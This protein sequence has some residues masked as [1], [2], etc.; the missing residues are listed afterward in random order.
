MNKNSNQL[1]KAG[2]AVRHILFPLVLLLWP[3]VSIRQGVTV[4]D[5][6]YSLA[7][8]RYL[9][10]SGTTWFYAT[11]LANK[12][13][14]LLMKLPL[15]RTMAGMNLL[16]SLLIS[17]TALM[18]YYVLKRRFSAGAVFLGE[19]IAIALCWCPAAILYNYLTYFLLTVG[20]LC[21]LGFAESAEK[22][23]GKRETLFLILAGICLGMNVGVRLSNLAEAALILAVWFYTWIEGNSGQ[24]LKKIL[25]RTG[26]CILG[27]LLGFAVPVLWSAVLYGPTAYFK[28]IPA[29]FS[30][31]G[32]V[33]SYT[34]GGMLASVASAYLAAGKWSLIMLAAAAASVLLF[35]V[36]LPGALRRSRIPVY[37]LCLAVLTRLLY[38]RGM[39]TVNYQDYWC[40]FSWG[41]QFLLLALLLGAAGLAGPLD[42]SRTERFYAALAVVLILVLPLGS[43]NYTFP[44][45]NCLFLIAPYV[46]LFLQKA[47]KRSG[48]AQRLFGKEGSSNETEPVQNTPGRT[49]RGG[50]LKSLFGM[51]AFVLVMLVLQGSLFHIRF[52]FRDGVDGTRRTAVLSSLPIA[53]GMRTTEANA[54]ELTDLYAKLEETGTEGRTA[55]VF[56]NAPGIH[57]LMEIPPAIDTTWPDLD[58]YPEE[59][60]RRELE[61]ISQNL[62]GS[63]LPLVIL[64]SEESAQSESSAGKLE[65][66]EKF[67]AD[68]H[69]TIAAR[70]GTYV[71]YK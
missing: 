35:A 36:P 3:L 37:V 34:L 54:G 38:G 60:F 58:S 50:V 49:L 30:T 31:A 12:L 27:Y 7:N 6:T 68:N 40:M 61:K 43:N 41:M 66:L 18:V 9:D 44:V 28:M 59:D 16:C 17:L 56:G 64:H 67:L 69:Y 26:W 70:A 25:E 52:A 51:T 48:I 45:L 11:F 53:K 24:L 57:Y 32:G 65:I 22:G 29:L 20:C 39:F 15:G 33:E 47:L 13:G 21:L 4:M 14:T 62:Q 19:W 71:I 55:L 23:Q 8:F 1:N 63:N 42:M 46:L 5:T 10:G 2:A